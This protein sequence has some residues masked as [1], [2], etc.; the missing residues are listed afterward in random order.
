LCCID[1]D[2]KK[3]T[4]EET[5]AVKDKIVKA[6]GKNVMVET[7]KSN[8]YH[9][10]FL[11]DKRL[12][13]RPDW[14]QK[15]VDNW[16]EL[17]YSKRFIACYLSKSNRYKVIH[18]SIHDLAPLSAKQHSSLLSVLH[19]YKGKEDKKPARKVKVK[20]IGK[21]EWEEAENYVKQ[22]EEKGIDITGDNPK[23]FKIGKS[24]ANAFGE[25]GFDLFNRVSQFS[26]KYN[27][28]TIAEDYMRFVE[29]D[30]RP[31]KDKLT[32]ATFFHIC[33]EHELHSM[34]ITNALRLNPPSGRKI[35]WT[36]ARA[37][38]YSWLRLTAATL[39]SSVQTAR[40]C[41]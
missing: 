36:R 24:I 19:P 7:T 30:A 32:S 6:L 20:E 25:K 2:T 16:I 11:F 5:T 17:Y 31:R 35:R 8:G 39:P 18:G 28:D 12:D 22:I 15:G 9:I 27:E 29:D 34:E 1:L 33:K 14:M 40:P 13:N 38:F 3:T 21:A 10:Y 23:W 37:M 41:K 4:I 26:P